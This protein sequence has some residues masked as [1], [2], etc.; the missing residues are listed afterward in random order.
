MYSKTGFEV[1]NRE[2]ISEREVIF[3]PLEEWENWKQKTM[4]D[5]YMLLI[6][7][8]GSGMHRI[9]F[10]DFDVGPKQFHLVQP[11]Q[12]HE[13]KFNNDVKGYSLLVQRRIFE[14]F[15]ISFHFALPMFI[16]Y[17]VIHM[18]RL[19]FEYLKKEFAEIANEM[20]SKK[21]KDLIIAR[22]FVIA[23]LIRRISK[24][25]FRE[26]PQVNEN[27]KVYNFLKLIDLFYQ[28]TRAVS[29]YAEKLNITTNHLTILCQRYFGS[30]ATKL[31][32]DRILLE[33]KKML[34]SGTS[35]KET[36]YALNFQDVSYFSRYFKLHTKIT[37]REFVAQHRID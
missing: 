2:A 20:H 28:S 14:S 15:S 7:E 17:P 19:E 36:A 21:M 22:L 8:S 33:A 35:V 31:I 27:P 16:K 9:D 30:T 18:Q 29:F 4:H 1:L 10:K 25:Y 37:P 34:V 3:F 6:F 23:F 26:Q 24:A 13:F 12:T 32:D 11:Q 5:Y